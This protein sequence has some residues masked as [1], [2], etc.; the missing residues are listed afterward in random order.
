MCFLKSL[1]VSQ[2]K[3]VQII[4]KTNH[5]VT[6]RLKYDYNGTYFINSTAI[7]MYSMSI[8]GL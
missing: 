8:A 7:I 3:K 6:F 5:Q 1:I 2:D 4:H